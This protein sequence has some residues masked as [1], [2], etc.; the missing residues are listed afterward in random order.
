MPNQNKKEKIKDFVALDFETLE[1]WRASVISVGVVVYENGE[2]VDCFDSLI[3]PPT[4]NEN[5]YCVQTHGLT[6]DDVKDAPT[7]PEVWEKIDKMIGDKPIVA[8]NAPFERS[9]I[10]ECANEF[11]TNADYKYIDTLKLSRNKFK[12]KKRHTLDEMCNQYRIRLAH[13]HNAL[14]DAIACGELY[15]KLSED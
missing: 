9:C 8:H 10:N 15:K 5:W 13:H 3:C 6:Y 14:S 4:K 7:F 12:N 2:I 11:G 1:G